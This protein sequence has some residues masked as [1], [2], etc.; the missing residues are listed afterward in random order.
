MS[1]LRLEAGV[2]QSPYYMRRQR[3][4]RARRI[5]RIALVAFLGLILVGVVSAIVYAG[6]PATLAQGIRVDGVDVGGLS[7]AEAALLLKHRSEASRGQPVTFS[8]AGHRFALKANQVGLTSDWAAAVAAA[9]HKGDG[10]GPLR[11]L[12]RA[13][14]RL[15]GG[16]VAAQATY[17]RGA[18]KREVARIAKV[19]DRP[20]REAAVVR[21]GLHASTV[22]ARA[23][24]VLDRAAA[25]T[26]IVA[27]LASM[28]RGQWIALPTKVDEP[29]VTGP[30]LLRAL[31]QTRT[32]LSAPVVLTVGPT[33]YRLPRWRIAELLELPANGATK[34]RIAG[35]GADKYFE[36]LQKVVNRPARDAQFVVIPN[37]I[38]IRPDKPGL[39]VDVPAT[40][41][42]LLAASVRRLNRVVPVAVVTHA[43]KRTTADAKAMGINGIVS[44][45][46]TYYGGVPNR[47]HNVQVVS[48]L[49]DNTLIG[50]GKEFSFNGTTGERNAAK[51]LLEAPVII[52]GELENG[53]GGGT[54]QVSTTVFNAAYEAGLPIT[55]RTNH[56]LYISHYPQGRDATVNYPDI[57]L[58]FVNDTGHW[59]LLRTFV[60]SSSLSV[61]LYGTPQHRRVESE[62]APLVTTG[63]VP[64]KQV[65]D[66]DLYVGTKVVEESGSAPSST[67]V[68]RRVYD[69]D[70]KLLYENTWYSSYVGEKE[71]VNVG[72]KPKPKPKPKPKVTNPST[73]LPTEP[74]PTDAG[75]TGAT[76]ATGQAAPTETTPAPAPAAPTV[77]GPTS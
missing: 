31:R 29:N 66:P 62:T 46:T 51:G 72:T 42:A 16:D 14:L 48:H 15:F 43:A 25:G 7:E 71:I 21:R 20:H 45:Y 18:L 5:R 64:V 65:P 24:R 6:S 54:C 60:S 69:Q 9:R 1:D 34:L 59:L 49:V 35:P 23:G 47:I 19:V 32:A 11:G 57:D 30:M 52:N 63:P 3:Q 44:S 4:A 39:V 36:R 8:V 55:A 56:A 53:L 67:S 74:L 76:G 50:P 70:G 13:E 41:R 28:S 77:P 61:N 27:A 10:F 38:T 2:T 12:R 33:R 75:T 58:K 37:G 73:T 26:A 40:A 17:D 22:P 68:T